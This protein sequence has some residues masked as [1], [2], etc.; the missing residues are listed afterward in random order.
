MIQWWLVVDNRSCEPVHL[1]S[2]VG[3]TDMSLQ[4]T[5]NYMQERFAALSKHRGCRLLLALLSV[6]PETESVKQQYRK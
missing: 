4:A 1:V 6:M 3:H 5:W 2:N